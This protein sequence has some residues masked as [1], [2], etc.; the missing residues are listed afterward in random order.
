MQ[1]LNRQTVEGLNTLPL[2]IM[3]FGGG[4]FLRAFVDWMVQVLNDETDFNAGV[5]VVKPTERGDYQEL[6]AQDGLFTVVL[7][8]IKNGELVAEKTIVDC[9][10]K[11]VHSYNEWDTYLALAENKDLRFV[12]SNTTE[13]GIKFNSDDTFDANPP[14]EFPAKLTRWLLQRFEYF[15][16]DATKGCILLPCELNENNGV[17]LKNAVLEYAD[18]WNLN[19]DFIKWINTSNYF[20]STLVDRIVSGYPKERAA[21]ILSET[22]YADDLLVAGE[23]YHSWVIAGDDIVQK[24]MPFAQTDLNV[25]FVND[26]APYREMK[27][28][29][30][31]GAHTSMV[32][33]GYLAGIRFVKEAMDDVTVSNFVESLL[34]EEA[35]KTLDFPTEVKQKFISAVLDRFRNPLLKHQLISISLNSTSKFVARLLPTLKDYNESEGKLPKRIVFGLSA[36]IRFY[37]GEFNGEKIELNDDKVVL[38]FFNT[39]YSKVDANEISLA[40]AITTILSNT[41][42]WGE[43]LTELKGLTNAVLNNIEN[44]ENKGVSA[45]I[46]L[47]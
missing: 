6:K 4:N 28:R 14:K 36:L 42:I 47:L 17:K 44:I 39:I 2:K 3:Q 35:A 8:G 43:D 24:E 5:V 19:D 20:C 1:K 32:P 31:N 23:Y 22:K 37:K 41:S 25:E 13:A 18:Y 34:E 21:E 30:L 38:D 15:N 16:G 10:Q 29:I 9:V 40:D 26:L 11:V 12:V 46:Q 33:V 7:D 45:S 27:V